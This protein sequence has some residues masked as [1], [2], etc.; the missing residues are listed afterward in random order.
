MDLTSIPSRATTVTLLEFLAFR[1]PTS[2]VPSRGVAKCIVNA[3]FEPDA[4][5]LHSARIEAL[6]Q[7]V[8]TRKGTV[9]GRNG[10]AVIKFGTCASYREARSGESV[11][12]TIVTSLRISARK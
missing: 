6:K 1:S 11:S 10:N 2:P 8:Y 9:G 5:T 3:V 4:V 7:S 12:I